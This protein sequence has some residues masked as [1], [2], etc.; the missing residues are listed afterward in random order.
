MAFDY[1]HF[2]LGNK[3]AGGSVQYNL[4]YSDRAAQKIAADKANWKFDKVTGVKPWAGNADEAI[5]AE[6]FKAIT[7]DIKLTYSAS[8]TNQSSITFSVVKGLQTFDSE[9]GKWVS[10]GGVAYKNVDSAG[11]ITNADILIDS[12]QLSSLSKGKYGFELLLHEIGHALGLFTALP[13]DHPHELDPSYKRDHTIMSYEEGIVGNVVNASTPMMYDI[14]ALQYLYGAKSDATSGANT[15]K[16]TGE[17]K[18]STIWD[19]G[20]DDTIDASSLKV[21]QDVKI[22]LTGGVDKSGNVLFSVVGTRTGT[23][24]SFTNIKETLAIGYQGNPASTKAVLIE[25]AIGGAGHDVLLGNDAA[26]TLDGRSGNDII[27]GG[28]GNDTI[29]GGTG[30]DTIDGGENTDTLTYKSLTHGIY[31]DVDANTVSTLKGMNKGDLKDTITNVEII[32]GTSFADVLVATGKS[33]TLIGGVGNDRYVISGDKDS[34]VT[35]NDSDGIGRI[36]HNLPLNTYNSFSDGH[37]DLGAYEGGI[38]SV[39]AGQNNAYFT[40]GI[41]KVNNK[42][43]FTYIIPHDTS[44]HG[45]FLIIDNFHSSNIISEVF[46]FN[47]DSSEILF[48]YVP[49]VAP[50]EDT[51]KGGSGND[52]LNS[53]D[54]YSHATGGAG[55]DV[56]ALPAT[57]TTNLTITDFN[58][59][60]GDL[61]DITG[62]D[63]AV[64]NLKSLAIVSDGKGGARLTIPES[65]FS[66]TLNGVSHTAINA[67]YFISN[68][69]EYGAGSGIAGSNDTTKPDTIYGTSGNDTVWANAGND[70]AYGQTGRDIL[71]GG[72]G[73]DSLW[74]GY[75]HDSLYGDAGNDS[76]LGEGGDDALYGGM[77]NDELSG[78][79]GNDKAYGG[80]GNDT[81]F[82]DKG[83]DTLYGDNGHDVVYG[84]QDADILYGGVGLDQLYGG[85]G[86]DTLL[87]DADNDNLY[88]EQGDDKLYGGTGNDTLS[89]GLGNDTVYGDAGDDYI[90]DED[91]N[92]DL[93]GMDGNDKIFGSSGNDRLYGGAGNDELSGVLGNDTIYGD[94]GNDTVRGS[95]G[96]DV[97]YG[98]EGADKLYGDE[99]NDKLLGDAGNDDVYGGVGNDTL[100]GGADNDS[101][102]GDAGSDRLYGDAGNDLLKG[103]SEN[104][105][106]YGGA[107][108][109][110][111][112]G[113]AGND[114][115]YGEAGNDT[116]YGNDGNDKLYGGTGIDILYGGAGADIFAFSSKSDSAVKNN[117]K[118]QDFVRGTDK[119]DLSA[120][121]KGISVVGT[122][123]FSSDG[124]AELRYAY[125]GNNTI[126]HLDTN[127]D[128]TA[129]FEL[130]LI[131]K[132]ALQLS[133]LV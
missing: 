129:D 10:A 107:G 69:L 126:A 94:A 6:A 17:N 123:A 51:A 103:G 57:R 102:Y 28:K 21:G 75:G 97:I 34:P 7:N 114:V 81:I 56:F 99:D 113:D 101:L 89:G 85:D 63:A 93:H 24:T 20:G 70:K 52:T 77:G 78:G 1:S 19:K 67:S 8:T 88:G 104:D 37:P 65:G 29:I 117:D 62:L 32:E 3:W 130:T 120:I 68:T 41:D 116:L 27:R 33:A 43:V 76:L 4:N 5:I 44:N 112:S 131:G 111:A 15:Y 48:N 83:S 125:S 50:G 128:G 96:K 74:G 100:Y 14:A 42:A 71:Y 105:T 86:N 82:G 106:L 64:T 45:V 73:N 40:A 46:S 109:D 90:Y 13:L 118:I 18:A 84:G 133:D 60:A 23:T 132:I 124:G 36:L 87:G 72:D 110:S 61:I 58:K 31:I 95:L 115:L 16:I 2:T 108:N 54:N 119:L 39:S 26:N 121:V 98:G 66:V 30:K 12:T 91:G 127:G 80:D 38:F 79:L 122:K 9:K 25:N 11:R 53:Y 47:A 92:N 55:A 49:V 59:A 22:D 35:I